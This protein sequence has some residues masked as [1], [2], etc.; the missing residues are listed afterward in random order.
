M[1]D[2]IKTNN[3]FQMPSKLSSQLETPVVKPSSGFQTP[4]QAPSQAAAPAKPQTPT[5]SKAPAQAPSQ[6]EQAPR[7]DTVELSQAAQARL[8]RLQGMSIPDIALRLRLDITIVN[9]FFPK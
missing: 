9:S 8:L 5:P 4:P 1:V 3:Q 2:P 6:G 7:G